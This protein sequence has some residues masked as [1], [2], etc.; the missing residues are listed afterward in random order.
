MTNYK[1]LQLGFS[2]CE[3][4][5]ARMHWETID[6]GNLMYDLKDKGPKHT[7]ELNKPNRQS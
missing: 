4:W 3:T 2:Q 1:L 6:Q 7:Q 5:I